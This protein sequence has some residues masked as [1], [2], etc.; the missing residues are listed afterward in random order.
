MLRRCS[1]FTLTLAS[2][3]HFLMAAESPEMR[4]EEGVLVFEGRNDLNHAKAIFRE[5][6]TTE[7]LP[8]RTG[9]EAL[10]HMSE[11]YRRQGSDEACLL[12]L[13]KLGQLYP[14]APPYTA[15]AAELAVELAR[16]L[17]ADISVPNQADTLT[18]QDLVRLVCAALQ[19]DDTREAALALTNLRELIESV[20]FEL[21]IPIPDETAENVKE[22]DVASADYHD[23]L[24]WV[25]QM[26]TALKEKPTKELLELTKQPVVARM[27][28]REEIDPADLNE[29]LY[30]ARDAITEALGAAD[31]AA[32]TIAAQPLQELLQTLTEAPRDL[33]IVIALQ[34]EANALKLVSGLVQEQK[35]K[36]ALHAWR[37][38]RLTFLNSGVAG[39]GMILQDGAAIPVAL[40]PRVI[41][42]LMFVED[43][44]LAVGMDDNP[45][46]A[47]SSLLEAISR[48]QK[49]T[50]ESTEE[51][52]TKRLERMIQRLREAIASIKAKELG[53]AQ[54][55]MRTE[56][57]VTP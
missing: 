3:A 32:F 15:A 40:Q 20:M 6:L 55:L 8:V 49:L 2:S 23:Y 37:E 22:R 14:S 29:T 47:T 4:L 51:A 24:E 39:Q 41:A 26:T 34:G 45:R 17:G 38:A 5:I 57:Y 50:T 44:L 16:D 54:D 48:L 1:I 36:E 25:L 31:G 11:V 52:C 46:H 13:R 33:A 7:N 53:R 56:I 18:S 9:A 42:A 12:V 30:R 19:L 27:E 10:W 21:A 43:A 35:F 28:S